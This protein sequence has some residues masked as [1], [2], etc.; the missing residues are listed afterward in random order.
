MKP[1]W[2]GFLVTAP[3]ENNDITANAFNGSGGRVNITAQGIYG[4]TPRSRAELVRLLG[5]NDPSKLDPRL[6]PTNDITAISQNNPTLSGTVTLNILGIDPTRSLFVLPS[7]PLDPRMQMDERCKFGSKV[8]RGSFIIT[9]RG[10][11][12]TDPADILRDEE[13]QLQDSDWIVLEQETGARLP[14]ASANGS[15]ESEGNAGR[16]KTEDRSQKAEGGN[17]ADSDRPQETTP[18]SSPTHP[19]THS[20]SSSPPSPPPLLEATGWIETADGRIFLVADAP[21]GGLPGPWLPMPNCVNFPSN[22]AS[23]RETGVLNRD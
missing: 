9:G 5:T 13:S 21:N 18:S 2:R 4:F 22:A 23:S 12:P 3:N 19:L 15:Q 20:R 16:Q 14:R 10:G 11:F 17:Q 1:P 7:N 6:L 8:S